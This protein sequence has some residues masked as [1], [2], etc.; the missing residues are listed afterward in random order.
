MHVHMCKEKGYKRQHRYS[1]THAH[2]P[3]YVWA[4]GLGYIIGSTHLHTGT[5]ES[6]YIQ[7]DT[8]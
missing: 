4:L 8:Q 2:T 5:Y 1:Y 6:A 3:A 7:K